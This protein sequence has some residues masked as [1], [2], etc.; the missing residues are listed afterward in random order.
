MLEAENSQKP[1]DFPSVSVVMATLGGHQ[2][3]RTIAEMNRGTVKPAE[4]LVCIPETEVARVKDLG[5]DNVRVLATKVRGQVAQRAEG[6]RHATCPIVMQLDDDILLAT[7]AVETML[8][9]LLVLGRGH[10]VGPVFY[11]SLTGAPLTKIEHGVRGFFFSLYETAVRGLPWGQLRMGALSNIG[12]CGSVDPRCC[13]TALVTTAWLPGGCSISSRED[14]I[15]EAFF[16]FRGKA[17]SEDV[18]HSYLRSRA[19]IVHHVAVNAKATILPPERG[20]T[21]DSAIAEIRARRYVAR[22]LG[23][24]QLRATFAAVADIVRRQIASLLLH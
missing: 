17:Y 16:P 19:G 1:V 11:N 9:S 2:I 4:I 15:L 3:I 14:L 20:V 8:R 23:G 21:K 18:L 7:D 10:V 6:F 5:F 12:G 24:S 22:T 13:H